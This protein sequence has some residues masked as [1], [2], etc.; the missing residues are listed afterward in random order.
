MTRHLISQK[1]A[2]LPH[3]YR[4]EFE[5]FKVET[6]EGRAVTGVATLYEGSDITNIV[7]CTYTCIA[8]CGD[9]IPIYS[10]LGGL[11]IQNV[12]YDCDDLTDLLG[13][14]V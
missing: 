8:T 14:Y 2:K 5:L 4:I 12:G 6:D 11:V 7:E 13:V 10:D 3:G 9:L 1:T